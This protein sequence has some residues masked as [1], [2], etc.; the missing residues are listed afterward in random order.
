MIMPEMVGKTR[1]SLALTGELPRSAGE[2]FLRKTKHSHL[3]TDEPLNRTICHFRYDS[4][5]VAENGRQ[6]GAADSQIAGS[7][8]ARPT[9][10][11][12][13]YCIAFAFKPSALVTFS[14]P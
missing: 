9:I 7:S 6:R 10:T 11:T 1:G 2:N 13:P 12:I 14:V 3:S 4:G 5:P 8:P